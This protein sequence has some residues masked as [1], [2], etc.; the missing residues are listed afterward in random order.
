MS[1]SPVSKDELERIALQEIRSFPGTEKVVSIEV[2]FGPDPRPGTS[3]WKLH[4]VAQEG[5]DLARIQY[6]AKTTSD[7]LKRRYEIHLN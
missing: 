6:A 5:C 4:V 1:R 2:E 7:R 3:D